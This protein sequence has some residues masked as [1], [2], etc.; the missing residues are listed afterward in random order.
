M[1][2]R[3]SFEVC[4]DFFAAL[5][6]VSLTLERV[7]VRLNTV[8]P[9]LIDTLLHDRM[10]ADARDAPYERMRTTLPV[11][12]MGQAQDVARVIVFVATDAFVTGSTVSVDGGGRIA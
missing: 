10:S 3:L 1:K 12:R 9:G 4:A 11:R 8:S 2:H 6:F 5:L 7:P